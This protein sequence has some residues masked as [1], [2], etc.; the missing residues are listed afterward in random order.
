MALESATYIDDLV[1]T[2]PPG[3][4][5]AS[6]ADDHIRLLK[7]VLKTTLP[8][9]GAVTATHTELNKLAGYTGSLPELGTAQAW[10]GQQYFGT[11]T[12]TDGA[13]IDW[14]LNIA[15]VAFDYQLV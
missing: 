8:L 12:L 10:T 4:D 14:N 6:T 2:N 3:T 9:T 5:N 7:A 13:G 1:S 15:Q 11:A